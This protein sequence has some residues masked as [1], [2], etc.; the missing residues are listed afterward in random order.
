MDRSRDQLRWMVNVDF[1]SLVI[2]PKLWT[3]VPLDYLTISNP[4]RCA[5]LHP[6]GEMGVS[7]PP[8]EYLDLVWHED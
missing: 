2:A 5:T 1:L 7:L 3:F 8:L 4:L 6:T